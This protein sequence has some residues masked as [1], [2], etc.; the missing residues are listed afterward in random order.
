MLAK[1]TWDGTD[2]PP[3][4]VSL[5]RENNRFCYVVPAG[6]WQAAEPVSDEVLVGCTVAPGFD[7]E[8]FTLLDPASYEAQWLNRLAPSLARLVTAEA[9]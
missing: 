8:D 9:I 5:S 3:L 2:T 6:T 7:F 4:R 1:V